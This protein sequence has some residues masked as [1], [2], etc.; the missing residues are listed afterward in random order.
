MIKILFVSNNNLTDSGLSGGDR[1]LIE[2]VRNWS[3][4]YPSGLLATGEGADLLAKYHATD[5]VKVFLSSPKKA[6]FQVYSNFNYFLHAIKRTFAG[7]TAVFKYRSQLKDYTHIYSASD[8]Y[9]DLLPAF[10]LKLL[11]PNMTWVA[12]FYLFAPKPWQKNNPYRISIGRFLTGFYYWLTQKLSFFLVY[13]FADI[14]CVTSDPDIKFFLSSKRNKDKIVV[15]RGGVDIKPS[16]LYLKKHQPSLKNKKFN[17]VFIGRLHYQK[18]VLE[19]IDIW[20]RVCNKFPKYQLAMIGNGQLLS[21]IKKKIKKLG[22]SKNITLFGF[23]DG[24]EKFKIFQES[25]IAIHPATYDSGGM[26]TAEAMAW[27]LPGVCFDLEALISYYPQGL[28]K[29]KC[30]DLDEFADNIIKLTTNDKLYSKYSQQAVDLIENHWSW[31][32]RSA[33]IIKQILQN[34]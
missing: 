32:S 17:A 18:G 8:F 23:V 21:D 29:T 7:I 24:P 27:G 19:L 25:A 28:I 6:K 34:S 15:V 10:L 14:V 12:G 16:H 9:P 33:D 22:L 20:K 2:L 26:A 31:D 4:K 11:Y 5:K 13:H 1:I 30:F 3:Q